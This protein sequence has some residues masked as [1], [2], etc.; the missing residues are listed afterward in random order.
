MN[1]KNPIPAVDIIIEIED[2]G[3]VLIERKN[4]QTHS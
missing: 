3:I 4:P 1:R 2:L